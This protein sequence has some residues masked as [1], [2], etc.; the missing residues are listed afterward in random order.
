MRIERLSTHSLSVSR[1]DRAFSSSRDRRIV[2]RSQ[3]EPR[4][5]IDLFGPSFFL[6]WT[7]NPMY[8]ERRTATSRI[9]FV[10]A[11]PSATPKMSSM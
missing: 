2:S 7:T 6:S 11:R 9:A 8:S 4:M 3:R 5:V 10:R 1:Y